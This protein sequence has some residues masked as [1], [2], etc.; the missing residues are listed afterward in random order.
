MKPTRSSTSFQFWSIMSL[1][2]SNPERFRDRGPIE[3]YYVLDSSGAATY[4]LRVRGL[5]VDDFEM[6]GSSLFKR[7]TKAEYETFKV[8]NDL[9]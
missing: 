9:V 2:D 3:Y 5:G 6:I 8:F 7:C 4:A 1:A